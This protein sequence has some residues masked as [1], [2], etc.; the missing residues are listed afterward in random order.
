MIHRKRQTAH[1]GNEVNMTTS[2]QRQPNNPASPGE[3]AWEYW[4]VDP[5]L[6]AITV[7]KLAGETYESAGV[8]RP[9]E[10][11]S[12]VLLPGFTVDVTAV[13]DVK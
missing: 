4:I 6:K 5:M 10:L 7:L 8:Y 2:T 13:F 1:S 9:G 3:P 12:W 11:A